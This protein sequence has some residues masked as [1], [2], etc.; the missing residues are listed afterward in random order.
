MRR[1]T[2]L[3]R[4]STSLEVDSGVALAAGARLG[5]YAIK[6]LIGQGAVSAV[7]LLNLDTGALSN[8]YR[9][10]SIA[11]EPDAD[12]FDLLDSARLAPQLD[13]LVAGSR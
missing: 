13:A 8:A 3:E 6:R 10:D 7:R 12:H 1:R 9:E 11:I 5:P 4:S 2:R